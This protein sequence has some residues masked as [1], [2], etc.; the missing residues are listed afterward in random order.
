MIALLGP[1]N[2]DRLP[3]EHVGTEASHDAIIAFVKQP[4]FLPYLT[5]HNNVNQV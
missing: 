5:Q 1:A 3:F 2:H 4:F